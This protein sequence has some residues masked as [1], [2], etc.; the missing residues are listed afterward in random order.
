MAGHSHLLWRFWRF[1]STHQALPS[2][3]FKSMMEAIALRPPRAAKRT[4]VKTA[5]KKG[6]NKPE[7]KEN[8][9]NA[10]AKEG[11][12]TFKMLPP[13][14]LKLFMALRCSGMTVRFKAT[15]SDEEAAKPEI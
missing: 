8:A 11:P 4:K 5:P 3:S 15:N 10:P 1:A 12:K 9:T 6:S 13:K 14:L 2:T 7:E